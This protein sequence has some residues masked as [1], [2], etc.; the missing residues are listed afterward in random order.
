MKIKVLKSPGVKMQVYLWCHHTW[1]ILTSC[2]VVA[3]EVTLHLVLHRS[4]LWSGTTPTTCHPPTTDFTSA[5]F[6]I[7]T[8]VPTKE[9]MPVY[10]HLGTHATSAVKSPK[11]K[12]VTVTY[13]CSEPSS[14]VL[15]WIAVY[16]TCLSMVSTS[17][18]ASS[19]EPLEI[20]HKKL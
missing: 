13:E 1:G 10:A 5:D 6:A 19:R 16:V 11:F 4:S 7:V 9:T 17:T 14:E 18:T 3:E 12:I 2:E 15:P 20:K 8:S